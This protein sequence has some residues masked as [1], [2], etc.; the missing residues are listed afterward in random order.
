M[1]V[2]ST[3][4]QPAKRKA[5]T[6]YKGGTRKHVRRAALTELKTARAVKKAVLRGELCDHEC[7]TYTDTGT[8]DD[9]VEVAQ[10]LTMEEKRAMGLLVVTQ[11]EMRITVKVCYVTEF[12]EPDESDWPKIITELTKCFGLH[13]QTIRQVFTACC[14]EEANPEKQK[15][16]AGRK[17]RLDRDNPGLIAGAAALNGSTSPKMATE[18]CNTE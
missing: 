13:P 2:F 9:N 11:E 8:E 18:I 14:N 15:E 6:A 1:G 16:G 12:D 4:C 5:K 17:M 7:D 10:K 3:S